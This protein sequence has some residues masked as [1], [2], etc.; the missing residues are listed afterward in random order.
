MD[1]GFYGHL[2]T[3]KLETEEEAAVIPILEEVSLE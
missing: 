1:E 3:Q 2:L